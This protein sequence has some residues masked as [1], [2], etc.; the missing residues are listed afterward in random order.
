V[1]A[2]ELRQMKED[3]EK[4]SRIQRELANHN[5][6]KEKE[7]EKDEGLYDAAASSSEESL[8]AREESS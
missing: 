8:G 3:L 5:E 1:E 2:M 7:D 4:V 6:K